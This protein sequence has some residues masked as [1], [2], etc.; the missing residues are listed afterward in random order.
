MVDVDR[1]HFLAENS[2]CFRVC[3]M[4]GTREDVRLGCAGGVQRTCTR[5]RAG[6]LSG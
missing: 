1:R 6:M 2:D 5:M 4:M 3:A